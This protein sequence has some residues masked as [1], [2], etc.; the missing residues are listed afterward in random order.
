MF[1]ALVTLAALATP[2]AAQDRGR[3]VADLQ[4]VVL[5]ASFGDLVPEAVVAT[6]QQAGASHAL[7]L[8]DDGSDP[9]DARGD[10]VWTASVL[11]EPAQY[12]PVVLAVEVDGVRRDVY[13]GVARVG[14]ERTVELAFDVTTDHTGQLVGRRRASASPGRVAHATEAVPLVAAGFWA[15]FL[16]VYGAVALRLRRGA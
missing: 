11:G 13:S 12:L 1:A 8:V 6:V 4:R 2:A 10:R 7:V 16:L 9:H 3:D 14:L 5:H 15:V